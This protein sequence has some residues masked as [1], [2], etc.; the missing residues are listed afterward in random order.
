MKPPY[1][2]LGYDQKDY[3]FAL[4][5]GV[6]LRN[7]GIRLVV[8]AFERLTT[9]RV[10]VSDSLLHSQGLIGILTPNYV[11]SAIGRKQ[12]TQ[13]SEGGYATFAVLHHPLTVSQWPLGLDWRTL[14]DFTNITLP[15]AKCAP[16]AK[17]L[18]I[19]RQ[20]CPDVIVDIKHS[21]ESAYLNNIAADILTDIDLLDWLNLCAEEQDVSQNTTT[22]VCANWI[23]EIGYRVTPNNQDV[24]KPPRFG[25]KQAISGQPLLQLRA[26]AQNFPRLAVVGAPAS[27]KS[28]L[29]RKLAVAA[30]TNHLE[31]PSA[32]P[33]PIWITLTEILESVDW[34]QRIM[35]LW[36]QPSDP[37]VMLAEGRASLFVDDWQR[38]HQ[39]EPSV[40]DGLLG[41]LT[42]ENGPKYLA[43]ACREDLYTGSLALEAPR[44]T[45]AVD[46]AQ[47]PVFQMLLHKRLHVDGAANT[48]R[49]G[50][51]RS[52]SRIVSA[53]IQSLWEQYSQQ[54]TETADF[55]SMREML[56][57]AA[58][59]LT[60][61]HTDRLPHPPQPFSAA[62]ELAYQIAYLT[63]RHG[64]FC[65][66]H[67]LI[68]SYF[69]SFKL[70]DLTTLQSVISPPTFSHHL[71]RTPTVWDCAVMIAAGLNEQT[72]AFITAVAA[73]DPYLALQ[74]VA[75]G[76]NISADC[77]QGIL[78]QLIHSMRI[79]GDNRIVLAKII[80]HFDT[81]TAAAL[82]IQTMRDGTWAMRQ[83]AAL[84]LAQMKWK[85]DI[86]LMTALSDMRDH[87]EQSQL[88][89]ALKRL[90]PDSTVSLLA[91]A[92]GSNNSER[93][94]AIWALGELH[95]R[96]A[97]PDL[98]NMLQD[99]NAEIN[100]EAALA[101]AKTR[102]INALP[103]L[104]HLIR[105]GSWKTRRVAIQSL[106]MYGKS[107]IEVL[108]ELAQSEDI[109]TRLLALETIGTVQE[110][111][112]ANILVQAAEDPLVEV[113]AVAIHGLAQTQDE[114]ALDCLM[115]SMNDTA[116]SARF[117]Q[118]ICDIAAE[119]L[120]QSQ[121]EIAKQYLEQWYNQE[122]A[123][124]AEVVNSSRFGSRQS[125]QIVKQ[126]LIEAKAKRRTEEAALLEPRPLKPMHT[127]NS[128]AIENQDIQPVSLARIDTD[129][130]PDNLDLWMRQLKED[131]WLRRQ[132]AARA[133]REHVKSIRGEVSPET[134][135]HL[136]ELLN[137]PDWTIRWTGIEALAWTGDSHAIE[138]LAHSLTDP[139][140]KVRVAALQSLAELG[141]QDTSQ[142]V[143]PLLF[144]TIPNV[145]ESAAEA[146]GILGDSGERVISNLE[147]AA[148]DTEEFVRLASIEALARLDPRASLPVLL[149]ALR[150][151][152][153][154]HVR[155]AAVNGISAAPENS[156]VM[157]L[158]KS[159]NDMSG[160]YW[161]QKRVCDV[162]AEILQRIGTKEAINALAKWKQDQ[163]ASQA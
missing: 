68:Q 14:V 154:S 89:Q 119:A 46:A 78:D 159:L 3:R 139:K 122:R 136:T 74:C 121:S 118:R 106:A 52:T 96:A 127:A 124:D 155:W 158:A 22:T 109:E 27:G 20:T 48:A 30:L 163:R 92:R 97:V 101:L 82:L 4:Q 49:E 117:N 8:D 67:S 42:G 115:K 28:S 104:A 87:P 95:E 73:T 133:I 143:I 107:G 152:P 131:D 33:I 61:Q 88:C 111:Q 35:Q 44:L 63:P 16:F 94:L 26:I 147:K 91:A 129:L 75:D 11:Q 81:A 24:S 148:Q 156:P 70:Q 23:D 84:L 66:S 1:L 120:G 149:K 134:I 13:M 45:L 50:E 110:P 86:D 9:Y 34:R 25:T 144:D 157:E 69:A 132:S 125:S 93:K 47:K 29:L 128:I 146:L 100:A 41:W 71:W 90:E 105:I 57:E 137:D 116:R 138:A 98:I 18:Q 62:L 39:A 56:V 130:A 114:H 76:V 142:Y 99:S 31:N 6:L 103:R 54:T 53:L 153:S 12:L 161:E 5:L 7:A 151:D 141:Q 58:F 162:V 83:N 2:V 85:P 51:N 160:P 77:Y 150:S 108:A 102:D 21:P 10:S 40:R 15:D 126:R 37:F 17:L 113:R 64:H 32:Q 80:Q 72:D 65:F 112:V 55:D 38:L 145:R 135:R 123:V 59:H 19:I 60:A 79:S 36:G 140:W 43:I